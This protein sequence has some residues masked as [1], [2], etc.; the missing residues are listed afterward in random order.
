MNQIDKELNLA[1][2][3]FDIEKAEKIIEK[4]IKND[5]KNIELWFKLAVIELTVALVDYIK[6]LECINKILDIDKNNVLALILECCIHYY[7]LGGINEDLFN[8]LNLIR[9]N[10]EDV[11]SIIKY[12]MSLYYED[13]DI[14]KQKELLEQSICL[15]NNYVTNYEELGK[16]YIIQ[17]D[18]DKGKKLIK[19]AY[20]NIKLVYNEEEIC[21]FTDVNEYIN[22]H[23][24]GIHLSWINKERI[25]EL[26]KNN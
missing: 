15:C 2:K 9:T 6:S 10:D 14:N 1:I 13:L 25:E 21:D 18:L 4:Q 23:V 11:L 17:G 12:I 22:E 19:K 26:L 5:T 7:H 24:K 16:I 20:D 8:K 3:N